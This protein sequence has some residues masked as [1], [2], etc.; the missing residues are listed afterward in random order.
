MKPVCELVVN[1]ECI[2]IYTYLIF[3]IL[4]IDLRIYIIL[5]YISCIDHALIILRSVQETEEEKKLLVKS[6][7]I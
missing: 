6:N 1:K 5:Y 3:L 4:H 2:Y 7:F